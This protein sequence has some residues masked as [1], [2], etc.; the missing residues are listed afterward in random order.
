MQKK[1]LY[2]N[3]F[4]WPKIPAPKTDEDPIPTCGSQ[5]ESNPKY[6][7][8]NIAFNPEVLEKY[9][10]KATNE[11]ER[12]MLIRL[13]FQFVESQNNVKVLADKFKILAE[14]HFG[15]LKECIAKLTKKESMS[16]GGLPDIVLPNEEEL[17]NIPENLLNKLANMN[18]SKERDT[19]PK[20]EFKKS[21]IEEINK[22][23]ETTK[24]PSYNSKINVC[25]EDSSRGS[26]DLKIDLIGVNSM[27]ECQLDIDQNHLVLNTTNEVY[28]ELKISLQDLKQKY[29]IQVESIEAKFVKKTSALKIKIPLLIKQ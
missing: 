21:L 27:N 14:T 9:G 1:E 19:Q 20:N 15:D 25:K 2:I 3:F 13:G 4:S 23:E 5:L 12:E 7:T 29:D 16:G 6:S 17:K 22:N 28:S 10:K 24:T 8:V 18:V 26:F 11:L